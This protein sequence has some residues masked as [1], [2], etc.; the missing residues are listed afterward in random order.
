MENPIISVITNNYNCGKYL[1]TNI[2]SI[3]S[4]DY[5]NWEHIIVDCGSTDE[6]INIIKS[7]AHN[8]LR[9]IQ[10]PFCGVSKG[11]DIGIRQ[12]QGEIIA[13]LDAD[14]FALP[15]RLIKQ[16]EVLNMNPS[17]VAVGGG[18]I[19]VNENSGRRKAYTYPNDHKNIIYLIRMGINPLPHSTLMFRKKS[20]E[21]VGGY[22]E[23]MEK[24][25][26]FDFLLRLERV[27]YLT[28]IQEPLVIYSLRKDSHTNRHKPKGRNVDYYS[29]LAI[30]LSSSNSNRFKLTHCKIEKWLDDIGLKCI[31]GILCR[32][33]FHTVLKNHND[34][35]IASLKIIMKAILQ[36][37]WK[38]SN[39]IT[40]YWWKY[41][42]TPEHVA[43]FI[44]NKEMDDF[45]A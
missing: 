9:L 12:A 43:Q 42:D 31:E 3:L 22:S 44:V 34:L 28:S 4:Q 19:R 17:T 14:D 30:I 40:K 23:V 6:S 18:I 36:R 33:A 24:S 21:E 8:K 7:N 26:D 38:I 32:W 45:I 5:D 2:D 1:R 37:I 16:V 29:I 35:D 39:C 10:I 20:Y 11:R 41:A 15:Q 27:G 13:I 25:E